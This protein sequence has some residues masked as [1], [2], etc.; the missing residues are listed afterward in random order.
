MAGSK[1]ASMCVPEVQP[2]ASS[3]HE[4][5]ALGANQGYRTGTDSKQVAKSWQSI[6]N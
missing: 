3:G 1:G 6:T 5:N 4:L 2:V